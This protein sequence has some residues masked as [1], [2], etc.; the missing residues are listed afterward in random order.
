M[1]NRLTEA[2]VRTIFSMAGIAVLRVK[3]LADGYGFPAWWFV[4][5]PVGW[6][7]IGWRK[8]VI[9]IDWTDTQV[10]V[11]VT[12]DDVAKSETGVHAE[13]EGAAVRYLKALRRAQFVDHLNSVS[14]TIADNTYDRIT[15]PAAEAESR[16]IGLWDDAVGT[17][18]YD[19]PKWIALQDAIEGLR[20]RLLKREDEILKALTNVGVDATCGA[21]CEIGF[22]GITLATH[23]CAV[24]A[25]PRALHE[26]LKASYMG[27]KMRIDMGDM[28]VLELVVTSVL[29]E[30]DG[31]AR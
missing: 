16:L 19:K 22:C 6:I 10:R 12:T 3:A 26:R 24:R 14:A 15:D 30:E 8:R 18:G 11:I 9:E 29:L 23:T 13:S 31:H 27:A 4:K 28:V 25:I 17:P 7:E 5:T 2:D 20:K 1:P 21:C